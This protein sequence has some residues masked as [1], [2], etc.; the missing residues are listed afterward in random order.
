MEKDERGDG[1]RRRG[2]RRHR[3][4][5]VRAPVRA[6][7]AAA[8]I[9]RDRLFQKKVNKLQ[10]RAHDMRAYF[11]TAAMYAGKDALWITD[12]TGHTSLVMLRT[13]ERDVRRWRELGEQPVNVLDAIPEFAASSWQQMWQHLWTNQFRR[14]R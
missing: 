6:H 1:R 5:E 14:P 11:V 13:Y 10:L 12:R 7:C 4:G 9:K 2:V 8:G 3:V